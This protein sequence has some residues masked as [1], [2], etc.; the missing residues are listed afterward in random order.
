MEYP[1]G[2][3]FI[4]IRGIYDGW[5]VAE[6]PDGTLINRWEPTESRYMPT[7]KWIDEQGSQNE[8]IR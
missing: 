6:L 7:Q 4:E 1:L 5:S 2:T 8:P 3:V